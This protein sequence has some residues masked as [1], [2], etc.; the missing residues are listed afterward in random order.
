MSYYLL[1]T[2]YS[3]LAA[4]QATGDNHILYSLYQ[5]LFSSSIVNV[6]YS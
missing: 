3:G 1:E 2:L 5:P 6:G 4:A